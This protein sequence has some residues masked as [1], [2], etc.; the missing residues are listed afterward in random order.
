[1][2]DVAEANTILVAGG[3][4]HLYYDTLHKCFSK[5]L[6]NETKMLLAKGECNGHDF[7]AIYS[8]ALGGYKTAA[9]ELQQDN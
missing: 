4:G 9:M 1:M 7:G 8:V 5:V 3:A 6:D 2:D